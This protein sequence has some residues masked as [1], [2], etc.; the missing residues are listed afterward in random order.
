MAEEESSG[1]LDE[2]NYYPVEWKGLEIVDQ[3]YT[4]KLGVLKKLLACEVG[5]EYSKVKIMLDRY[6]TVRTRI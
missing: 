3:L 1:D 6:M 4:N 5:P 2:P